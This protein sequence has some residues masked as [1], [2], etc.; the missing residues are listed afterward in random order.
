MLQLMIRII[1]PGR[2][3]HHPGMI[4][5]SVVCRP[6]EWVLGRDNRPGHHDQR[7]AKKSSKTKKFSSDHQ[8]GPIDNDPDKLGL[9]S[10]DPLFVTA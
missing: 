8:N 3:E 9:A 4:F 2:I 7:T 1:G 10:P 6:K 5:E